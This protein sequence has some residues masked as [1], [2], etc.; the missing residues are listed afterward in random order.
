MLHE[1][2]FCTTNIF[3][4]IWGSRNVHTVHLIYL[5]IKPKFFRY[6]FYDGDLETGCVLGFEFLFIN[7]DLNF[8]PYLWFLIYFE[9]KFLLWLGYWDCRGGESLP[10]LRDI[11]SAPSIELWRC[12]WQPPQYRC[13]N[14][15]VGTCL[16]RIGRDSLKGVFLIAHCWTPPVYWCQTADPHMFLGRCCCSSLN[17]FP[18]G[19]TLFHYLSVAF[20]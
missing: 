18:P 17:L 12:C 16:R 6:L 3:H 14:V 19:V 7:L 9:P 13:A 15:A 8:Y 10:I 2:E 20:R 4:F 1:N 11:V 5:S